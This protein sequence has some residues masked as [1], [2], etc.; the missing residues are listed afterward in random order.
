MSGLASASLQGGSSA[1]PGGASGAYQF[2]SAST[3]AGGELTRQSATVTSA[4]ADSATAAAMTFRGQNSR[5]GTDTDVAGGNLVVA[6]GAGTG[7]AAVTSLQFQTPTVGSTGS[8]QQTLATRLTLSS[9]SAAFTVPVSAA[10]GTITADAQCF[11][12]T[13]AWNNAGVAF[14][15]MKVNAVSTAS[16]AASLL[17]DLQVSGVS[18]FSVSKAGV[19]TAVS[20]ITGS[21]VFAAAAGTIGWTGRSAMLSPADGSIT[22]TNNA[23]SAFT[24]LNFGGAT[25]SFPALKR[26]SAVLECKLADDSAYAYMGARG[27]VATQGWITASAPVLDATTTWNAGGTTFTGIKLNVTNTASAAASLLLDLQVGSVTMFSIDKLGQVKIN[28]GSATAGNFIQILF[29]EETVAVANGVLT[30]DGTANFIPAGAFILALRFKVGTQPGGTAWYSA[31][32]STGATAYLPTGTSTAA[33]TT[34]FGGTSMSVANT[35]GLWIGNAARTM[36][37]TFNANTSDALGSIT[38]G[39]WYILP[40][41]A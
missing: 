12:G 10:L 23:G 21:N 32:T 28:G 9:A 15:A 22:L 41:V 29:K 34:S 31:G 40:T 1:T 27:Y 33:G 26:S 16:G 7:A 2:N 37:F 17:L 20:T 11:S 38:Y 13:V 6:S 36:R 18:Q 8:A 3:F 39:I 25:S 14:T 24:A 4:G 30:Q 19:V 5:G 35:F